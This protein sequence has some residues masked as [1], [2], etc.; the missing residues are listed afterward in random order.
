MSDF[1]EVLRGDVEIGSSMSALT[2]RVA[3]FEE[4]YDAVLELLYGSGLRVSELAGLAVSDVDPARRR[5]TVWG[6]GSKQ[7][8]VPISPPAVSRAPVTVP[9]E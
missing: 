5:A 6:K 1:L 2:G 4:H 8:L 9:V 7:R 3:A